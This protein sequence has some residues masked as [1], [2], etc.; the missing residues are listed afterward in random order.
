MQRI[1]ILRK[2]GFHLLTRWL[3]KGLLVGIILGLLSQPEAVSADTFVV[4][5][6]SDIYDLTNECTWATNV[7]VDPA[8]LPG[9]D[10][11]VSLREAIC[12]AN[13][14]QGPDV[15]EFNIPGSPPYVISYTSSM[16]SIKQ[17]GHNY[18][19]HN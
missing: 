11:V 2:Q 17:W 9:S 15:I 6:T 10:G 7:S 8:L 19:W 12:A 1:F 4:N 5:T 14:N 18:R 16:P 13:G 3:G